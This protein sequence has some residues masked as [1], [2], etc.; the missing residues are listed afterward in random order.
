MPGDGEERIGWVVTNHR[1]W[2]N[3]PP[4]E[5]DMP[6]VCFEVQC[7]ID[8]EDNLHYKSRAETETCGDWWCWVLEARIRPWDKLFTSCAASAFQAPERSTS[9]KRLDGGCFRQFVTEIERENLEDA[10]MRIE[11]GLSLAVDMMSP[12]SQIVTAVNN[13][14]DIFGNA[15][16]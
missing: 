3:V 16:N 10:A 14:W 6:C 12:S 7:S 4:A 2:K 15:V 13:T 1:E 8:G 11:R 5:G 9:V